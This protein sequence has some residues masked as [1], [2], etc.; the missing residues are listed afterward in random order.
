MGAAIAYSDNIYAV[1]THLF[2]GDGALTDILGRVGI[3][4][5]FTDLPSL[6][7][8]AEE[9]DM[10]SMIGAY[11]VLANEGYK[12]SPYLIRKVT[13]MDGNTLYEHDSNSKSI[14]VFLISLDSA[15]FTILYIYYLF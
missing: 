4:N 11:S 5:H 8:G 2:L 1:K 9:I 12:I 10:M 7:L 3:T 14:L 6:A 15:I 13:D